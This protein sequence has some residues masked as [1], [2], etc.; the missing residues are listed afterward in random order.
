MKGH[1]LITGASSG[2][3]EALARYAAA[4]NLRVTV[5]ARRS[6]RL[7]QLCER[8]PNIYPETADISDQK[9]VEDAIDRAVSV[10]GSVDYAVLNAGIYQPVDSSSFDCKVFERHMKV[11]Y[12]GV[13]YCLEA[14]IPSMVERRC[15]HIALMGSTAGYRGLPR[16]AAYGPTKAALQNLAECLYFDLHRHNIKI[17]IINPGFVQTEATAINDF[18]MPDIVTAETAAAEIFGQMQTGG[19]EVAF[20]RSFVLKIKLLSL[21]PILTYLKFVAWKTGYE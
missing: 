19:F 3:G 12:S 11:N 4:K 7:A 17:Q 1:Y 8:Y 14:L 21:V 15:G 6:D 13:L 18:D 10:Q 9:Q 2:I 5:I 20:P 16:S